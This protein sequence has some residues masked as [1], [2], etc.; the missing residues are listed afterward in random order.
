M[1]QTIT[2]LVKT[3]VTAKHLSIINKWRG[4]YSSEAYK[5]YKNKN[6]CLINTIKYNTHTALNHIRGYSSEKATL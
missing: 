3:D 5:E 4:D 1:L 6:S 2:F